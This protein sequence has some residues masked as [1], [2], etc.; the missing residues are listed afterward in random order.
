MEFITEINA[1][2]KSGLEGFKKF[3][4][5][6]LQID[7]NYLEHPFWMEKGAQVTV[8]N[9]LIQ[10]HQKKKEDSV[11]KKMP[12]DLTEFID[13]VL[14][15]I[16]NK[17]I[18][19]PLHQA[20]AA[21]KIQLA[22]HLLKT[23]VFDVNQR[24]EEGRT[25]L[26]LA[27]P[28]KNRQL[29]IEILASKP[30]VNATTYLTEA[31]ISSQPL[32]QAIMLDFTSG[33]VNLV[34]NGADVT[35]PVGAAKD[36]PVLLAARK[37]KIKALEALL[38][39]AP[40]AKLKLEAENIK[41]SDGNKKGDN[42]IEALCKQLNLNRNNKDLLRGVAMLLCRGAEPPRSEALCQLLADKRS[43]LLKEIDRYMDTRPELV[44]PFVSRCHLTDSAL[45]KIIYID[46]SWGS[47]L[48]Q[49][50][51]RPSDAAFAIERLVTRK[52]SRRLEGNTKSSILP[53]VAAVPLNG[54]EPPFK[55]YAEFVRRYNEA[56]E[57]QKI[58]N[59]WSTMR[60]MIAGG[61]CNWETVKQYASTHQGTRTQ[62]IYDD[63]FKT[64]PKMQMHEQI[65]SSVVEVEVQHIP[66]ENKL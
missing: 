60:W 19:Q 30:D 24:D 1:A 40:A 33:V 39:E 53:T 48:W 28:S 37:G 55:L 58:T 7:P 8:L 56:Y 11:D 52:Y 18:G 27:L 12:F 50:L 14:G 23:N 22:L 29:L 6:K 36:T 61:K 10:Q 43:D 62:I 5:Q 35:N 44:D 46:H 51:G 45:H 17:N 3:I 4:N 25:L 54:D 2:I 16:Q 13:V 31:R 15:R 34:R 65:E 57:N 63:M 64:L 59:P 66:S 26:S 38:E 49:L 9:Y 21:G 42:A 32:H 41:F 47:T 20:I